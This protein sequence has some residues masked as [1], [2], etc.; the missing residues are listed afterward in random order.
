MQD[1]A[2]HDC[3][4][5][6]IAPTG[7]DMEQC[8]RHWFERGTTLVWRPIFS[9]EN[10]PAVDPALLT[11]AQAASG[12]CWLITRPGDLLTIPPG[13]TGWIMPVDADDTDIACG[14]WD[15]AITF[16]AVNERTTGARVTYRTDRG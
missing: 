11:E 4:W 6:T 14:R 10:F 15:D 2:T 7:N 12:P 13:I 8:V 3:E 16:M 5:K 9:H 1:A